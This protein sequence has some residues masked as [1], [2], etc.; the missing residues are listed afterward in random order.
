MR[1]YYV[2]FIDDDPVLVYGPYNLKSAKDFARIGSQPGKSG[3]GRRA[4]F[5]GARSSS[6]PVR[7]YEEGERVWPRTV[8][9]LSSLEQSEVPRVLAPR[10]KKGS[11]VKLA[12][13]PGPQFVGRSWLS[14]GGKRTVIAEQQRGDVLYL[15]VYTGDDPPSG[16]V[17]MGTVII[18]AAELEAEIAR[19]AKGV[20]FAVRRA[21]HLAAEAQQERERTALDGFEDTLSPRMRAVAVRALTEKGVNADGVFYKNLRDLIRAKISAGYAVAGEG[22]GRR[23]QAPNG[24]FLGQQTIT[25]L[26][27]DYA[28]YLSV[29]GKARSNPGQVM[30]FDGGVGTRVAFDEL[31]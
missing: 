23:L 13:N 19:D 7:V 12:T 11:T 28:A 6:R 29:Q 24:A 18:P 20:E 10:P 21:T 15:G 22:A 3:G 9:A 26:G 5:T 31:E 25:K 30:L 1:E 2:H 17:P 8:G 14:S 4:V 16:V 27:M